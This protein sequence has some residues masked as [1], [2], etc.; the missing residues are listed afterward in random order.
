[1]AEDELINYIF[2]Q[3]FK[4][5]KKLG[6]GSFGQVYLG[7]NTTNDEPVA[8]KLV[9]KILI[10]QEAK[11]AKSNLLEAEAY[12]LI[13]LKDN[14]VPK[15]I[16]YGFSKKYNVL[17]MELLGKSLESL[18][19]DH[20]KKFKLKTVCSLATDIFK[21]IEFM[22]SKNHVHRD[23]KPDNF[24]IG[25]SH[26]MNT[27]DDN[28]NKTDF[29]NNS[30][31]DQIYIIDLGLSKKYCSAS[32]KV[33]NPFKTGKSMTGTAR[34]C[35]VNTHRGYEQSRRDDLE[36][37]TYML[38]YFLKG[39]LPWQGLH[40]PKDQNHYDIIYKKKCQVTSAELVGD[41]PSK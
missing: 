10:K 29:S 16:C 20:N 14:N 28:D 12:R 34:Y 35:S 8:I 4:V 3:K 2:F 39:G 27:S 1:M 36:S 9:N 17:V 6:S 25:Y 30:G 33:H 40:C 38:L 5:I 26:Q 31:P 32:T 22:H 24:T 21:R 23:I 15:V 41:L 18:F 7:I 11:S 19:Q 37:I 13:Y